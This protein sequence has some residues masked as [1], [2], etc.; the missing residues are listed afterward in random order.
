MWSAS[1]PG[2]FTPQETALGA[3]RIGS[4]TAT[5][6]GVDGLKKR[7]ILATGRNR[8]RFLDRTVRSLV[9]MPTAL[10]KVSYKI[11]YN[12]FKVRI[13]IRFRLGL[14]KKKSGQTIKPV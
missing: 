10:S 14:A 3:H 1:R 7:E 8:T 11:R 5:T 4:W 2:N 13:R 12:K 6:T 9:S